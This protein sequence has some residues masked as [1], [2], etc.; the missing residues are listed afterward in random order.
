MRLRSNLF[1]CAIHSG[2]GAPSRCLPPTQAAAHAATAPSSHA[3]A[4]EKA[5]MIVLRR[6]RAMAVFE[7]AMTLSTR[8]SASLGDNPVV[9]ATCCTK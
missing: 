4:N 9:E 3:V 2:N 1:E 8:R 5:N 7:F 6:V